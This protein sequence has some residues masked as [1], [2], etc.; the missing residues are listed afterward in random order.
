MRS[1]MRRKKLEEAHEVSVGE[2]EKEEARN[3][4]RKGRMK[5]IERWG[6]RKIR[7]NK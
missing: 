7:R 1:G 6:R 5:K 2:V 4:E 3:E